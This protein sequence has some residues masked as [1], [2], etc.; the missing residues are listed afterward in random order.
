MDKTTLLEFPVD[1]PIKV[2]GKFEPDFKPV[3][4]ALVRER[5][6]ELKDDAVTS[7]LSKEDKFES[8]TVTV[9]ATS[10]AQLDKL[11]ETLTACPKVLMVL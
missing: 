6:P 11:Y 7:K 2:M 4:I 5:F 3:I 8:L 1:F 9:H 10:Q